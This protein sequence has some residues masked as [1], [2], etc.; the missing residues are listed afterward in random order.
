MKPSIL[1]IGDP[2]DGLNFATDT[3]LA[4]VEGALSLGFEVHWTTCEKIEL[5][6]GQVVTKKPLIV[7]SVGT[8]EAPN[9]LPYSSTA[10]VLLQKYHRIFVRKDPPF[11]T[12]YVDLCW[13]L[14]QLSPQL[15]INSPHSLLLYHEKLTPHLL[16]SQGL[17]PDHSCIPTLISRDSASLLDFA[18]NL[19]L[20]AESFIAPL[21]QSEEFK[22]FS[23]QWIAKPW[24]GHGGRGVSAFSD[25]REFETWLRGQPQNPTERTLNELM[26]I[27]P[28]LP[29]IHTQGDRRVF[30]VNGKVLFDFV[31]RPAHGRIEANLAQGGRAELNEMPE[32]LRLTAERIA[33]EL[34]RYGILIAGLDFIGDKLTEVNITSPTGVRTYEKL[35]GSSVT[36]TLMQ[37][38]MGD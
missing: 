29:E 20:T 9:V 15:T 23:F 10:P 28:F 22:N 6:N 3:S 27:Q 14:S 8:S 19:R 1:V 38:L 16:A 32:E 17:L 7:C 25:L 18:T 31:R 21:A 11:D 35:T 13:L 4:M 26:I 37:E 5:M 2:I 12:H 24:R 34:K 36:K 30:V 33:T